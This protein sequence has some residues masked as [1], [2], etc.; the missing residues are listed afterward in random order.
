M[1]I[2]VISDLHLGKRQYGIIARELDFYKQLD[3]VVNKIN[4]LKCDLVI[5]AGDIFDTPNPSPQSISEYN[6]SINKLE[7]DNIVAIKGNHTM[8]LRDSHYP[9]DNLVAENNSD[10]YLLEDEGVSFVDSPINKLPS[11][12]EA[13]LF[14]KDKN[15]PIVHVDGISYRGETHVEEFVE[16]Q[17][18]LA[19]DI[20]K[21]SDFNILVVHEAFT[22]Y[23]GFTGANL[24]INDLNYDPYN[25]IICGH[26]HT[27][28]DQ[29]VDKNTV[30]IQPGSIERLNSAEAFDESK[31][32]KGFYFIDTNTSN[33]EFHRVES[34][35]PFLTGTIDL[36]TNEDIENFFTELQDKIDS[37]EVEPVVNYKYNVPDELFD[38]IVLHNHLDN[39]LIDKSNINRIIDDDDTS[40]V[41]T[42]DEVPTSIAAVRWASVNKFEDEDEGQLFE[43]LYN[44]RNSK[45]ELINIGNE[46]YEK[47]FKVPED[48][49]P[50]F[51]VSEEVL[52]IYS[53]FENLEV[54]PASEVLKEL[55]VKC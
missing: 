6:K 40:L 24:S 27:R 29:V 50:E 54:K 16:V 18:K 48:F 25:V 21:S 7:C 8:I 55:E 46:F 43:A 11:S 44:A 49:E 13:G 45:E 1:K 31:N 5:I 37:Y 34:I 14:L 10:Y 52:E 35:R 17:K 47:H 2:A 41:I 26:V 53:Y 33:I 22:E 12:A 4:D 15:S 39:I 9:A 32:G 38:S 51:E 28:T 23:C 42:E 19:A 30:F 20:D 3:R 36:D